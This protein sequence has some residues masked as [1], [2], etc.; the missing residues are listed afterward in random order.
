MDFVG[1]IH[2]WNT[3]TS[4]WNNIKRL[5][6]FQK[7]LNSG[8]AIDADTQSCTFADYYHAMD[9]TSDADSSSSAEFQSGPPIP[10][11]MKK[12]STPLKV[13]YN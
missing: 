4:A 7:S 10:D 8:A 2:I 12:R 6:I 1:G 3:A 11:Y 9:N 13:S 5:D